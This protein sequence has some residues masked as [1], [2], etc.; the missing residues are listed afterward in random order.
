MSEDY[1]AGKFIMRT[2][3]DKDYDVIADIVTQECCERGI[4]LEH[5]DFSIRVEYVVDTEFLKKYHSAG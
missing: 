2:F 1:Q 4:L 5:L 3:N